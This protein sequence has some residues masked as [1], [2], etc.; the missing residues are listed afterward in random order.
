ML[1]WW[2]LQGIIMVLFV[3]LYKTIPEINIASLISFNILTTETFTGKEFREVQWK[4]PDDNITAKEN[5]WCMLNKPTLIV[6]TG[7]GVS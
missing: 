5:K 7:A 4:S 1:F 2:F 3:N 6:Q